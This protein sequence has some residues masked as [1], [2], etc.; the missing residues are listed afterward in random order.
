MT[1]DRAVPVAVAVGV[2]TGLASTWPWELGPATSLPLWALVGALVGLLVGRSAVVSAGLGYGVA[3]TVAFLYSRYGGSAGHLP[4]YTAFVAALS[5]GGAL[6]GV[7][8]AFAGSRLRPAAR[9]GVSAPP[10][11]R[12]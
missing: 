11:R 9:D 2:A 3:L 7:V 5:V 8:T 10:L 6:A 12:S 1:R 4:A